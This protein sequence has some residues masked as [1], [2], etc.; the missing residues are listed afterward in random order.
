MIF[1]ISEDD[2][3]DQNMGA[4]HINLPCVLSCYN[5]KVNQHAIYN[6]QSTHLLQ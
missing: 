6:A 5:A 3:H 4:I 1:L 2:E